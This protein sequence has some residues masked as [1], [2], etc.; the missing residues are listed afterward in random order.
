MSLTLR[1][2]VALV[3][4]LGIGVVISASGNPT[5]VRLASFVEPVGTLWVNAIRMTVIP[6]VVSLLIAGIASMADVVAIGRTGA[7][8]LLLF[9]ALLGASAI[10]AVIAAPPLFTRLPVDPAA[11]ASLAKSA[12]AAA[13]MAADAVK[14]VPSFSQWLVDLVPAN[15]IRAAADG[16]MLPLVI[17][18][19]LFALASTRTTTGMRLPL[20]RFFEAVSET[21]LVLV[22][23]MISLAPIGVFAL[24]LTLSARVG[25]SVAGAMGYYVLV[26]C[27]MF[28]VQMIA[29][30][31]VAALAGRVPLQRFAQAT[32]TAQVVA[33]SSRSSLASL[34]A[35]IEGAD[36]RLEL[37]AG[38][39]G[40]VLPLAVST[41]KIGVPT[42]WVIGAL[43]IGRLYAIPLDH[44]QIALLAAGAILLSFSTPGIPSGSLV[45]MAPLVTSLGLPVEGI[46]ILIALDVFP[47]SFKT[48]LNVTA[49]MAVATIL[50]RR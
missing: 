37:H 16:A 5:L 9:V 12:A 35:L 4:G 33:F 18:S 3:A 14:T 26:V 8:A 44:S 2:L 30:Y 41:F 31:P 39:S 25:A 20:V 28:A 10:F 21:M 36:K 27:A 46:G 50:S 45:L 40:F 43:F 23:W 48:A 19:V 29:L 11:T 17:F 34:P 42:S 1:V 49:D 22:R 47:D 24:V 15:P 38:I 7:R 6:L 32:F 13:P